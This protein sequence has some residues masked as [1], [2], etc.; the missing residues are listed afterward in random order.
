MD[1]LVIRIAIILVA[2]YLIICYV[3]AILFPINLWRQDYYLLFELCV[4]LCISKQGVYHCKYLKYTAYAILISD[5]LVCLVNHTGFIDDYYI[6]SSALLIMIIGLL[7]TMTK[8]IRH[9]RKVLSIKKMKK[10]DKGA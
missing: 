8:A 10:N 1:K 4:C 2:F 5:S 7:I 3:V 9:Y 6:S